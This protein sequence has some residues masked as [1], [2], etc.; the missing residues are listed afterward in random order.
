[1]NKITLFIGGCRLFELGLIIYSYVKYDSVIAFIAGNNPDVSSSMMVYLI[2]TYMG[3]VLISNI[4][5][6]LMLLNI[7][8]VNIFILEEQFTEKKE[9]DIE[10]VSSKDSLHDIFLA[11]KD[12]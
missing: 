7:S 6:L 10:A 4:I 2:F 1:M 3:C 9:I 5:P 8:T 11:E 12:K